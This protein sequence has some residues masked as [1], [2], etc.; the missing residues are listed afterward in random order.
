MPADPTTRYDHL[1]PDADARRAVR[2]RL[3]LA[4]EPDAEFE[5]RTVAVF[6]VGVAEA[7]R[8]ARRPVRLRWLVRAALVLVIVGVL[9]A[10]ATGSLATPPGLSALVGGPLVQAWNAVNLAVIEQPTY[11]PHVAAAGKQE[12]ELAAFHTLA[13]IVAEAVLWS[14]LFLLLTL[15]G[16]DWLRR[17][18]PGQGAGSARR[19]R[20]AATSAAHAGAIATP[21]PSINHGTSS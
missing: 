13:A 3:D 10:R 2:P 16:L 8:Q 6:R 7:E 21:D 15:C 18:R 4:A 20:L 11:P 17:H 14:A 5:R 19:Q 1:F 9:V 12:R